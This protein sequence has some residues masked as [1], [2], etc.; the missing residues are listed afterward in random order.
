VYLFLLAA[1]GKDAKQKLT[2]SILRLGGDTVSDVRSH[3]AAAIATK[4]AVENMEEGGKGARAMEELKEYGIH[5]VPSKFIKDAA[6]GKVLELIEKMNL[7]PWGSD[8]SI[9]L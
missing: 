2:A 7:A 1:S 8:V 9:L 4:A 6:N 3:V 5:V